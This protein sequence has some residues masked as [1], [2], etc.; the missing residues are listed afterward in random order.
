MK[1]FGPCLQY[2]EFF[3]SG[4]LLTGFKGLEYL[5]FAAVE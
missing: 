2:L 4:C 3:L 1:L 5:D